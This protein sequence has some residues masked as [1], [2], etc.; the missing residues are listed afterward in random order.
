[1]GYR[2][3]RA[4][5]INKK[6]ENARDARSS[7]L[8]HEHAST[9]SRKGSTIG[10]RV[11]DCYTAA[12][13]RVGEVTAV[14]TVD[15]CARL[16]RVDDGTAWLGVQGYLSIGHQVDALERID[17]AACGPS[18]RLRPECGPYGAL[19]RSERVS[20]FIVHGLAFTNRESHANTEK[21]MF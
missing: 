9:C 14:G 5:D 18:R 16:R 1:L 7:E 13:V 4:R 20:A 10:L 11:R 12:R 21:K 8:C 15:D 2:W 3:L 17:L 6:R 19:K